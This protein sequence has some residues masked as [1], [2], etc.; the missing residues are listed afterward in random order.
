[1]STKR[2]AS[3]ISEETSNLSNAAA[4]LVGNGCGPDLADS[5]LDLPVVIVHDDVNGEGLSSKKNESNDQH[6]G[7]HKILRPDSSKLLDDMLY[8]LSREEFLTR[9][10]KK[11]AVCIQRR[12]EPSQ[13][14]DR[15]SELVSLICDKYLFGLDIRQIFAETSSENVFLWLRPP[16]NSSSPNTLNSVEISDPDTAYALHQSG[17]HPAYCRAPPLLEQLLVGSLLRSTGLGGGHYHPPHSETTTI[18]GNTTL[19]RGEVELFI[20]AKSPIEKPV[21]GSDET[22]Q[23]I[24]GAHT[25]FQENFTI[26]LSGIKQWTLRRSRVRHPLR[27]TTPHYCREATVVENQLKVNRLCCMHGDGEGAY[28]FDYEG[29]NTDGAEQ[30]IT[31]YPGD[32]LYFPSGMWHTGESNSLLYSLPEQLIFLS[33]AYLFVICLTLNPH[34]LIVKTIQPGVSLNVSLMGT[35]YANLVCEALQH[36]LVSDERWRE[37]VTS[38]PGDVNGASRLQELMN[39]LSETVDEFVSR[40]GAQSV[41]PPVL[42]YPPTESND[43]EDHELE[44]AIDD[45]S[46]SMHEVDESVLGSEEAEDGGDKAPSGLVV[47]MDSFCGPCGW[48][49]H[50]PTGGRLVKN[51]LALLMAK[52]EVTTHISGGTNGSTDSSKKEYILNVNYGG[53]EMFESHIRV[54]FI[55]QQYINLMDELT[56][57]NINTGG[58]IPPD[59]L[60]YYGL[61]C[62]T[63]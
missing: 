16:S 4:K 5:S 25:D 49:C 9:H 23:H 24:T 45:D 14:S 18:G 10:F 62:W 8:P 34:N 50:K 38:R 41:L 63:T 53:N 37:V 39:G 26:Q 61:F 58:Q 47:D 48:T 31:L 21:N 43:E 57:D 20:G 29:N 59:C 19:G 40:G 2:K 44:D 6:E 52:E 28:G 15:G 30:T 32:V 11:N 36:L 3:A 35:T 51:P 56:Q 13:G 46:E 1:M 27:A 54:T 17:S 33:F 60:F 55:T 7:R 42:C 12:Q 22:R